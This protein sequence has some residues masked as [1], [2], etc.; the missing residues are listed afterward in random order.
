MQLQ[1][2]GLVC[3]SKLSKKYYKRTSSTGKV[4]KVTVKIRDIHQIAQGHGL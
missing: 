1:G 2:H 3:D 4:T